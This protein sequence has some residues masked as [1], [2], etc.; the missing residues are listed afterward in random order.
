MKRLLRE[1]AT[2]RNPDGG[3]P[4]R[5]GPSSCG[6]C[7]ASGVYTDND[8]RPNCP[9]L[10]KRTPKQ[11]RNPDDVEAMALA[12][13]ESQHS[14]QRTDGKV[15]GVVYLR[16]EDVEALIRSVRRQRDAAWRKVVREV[17]AEHH[18]IGLDDFFRQCCD[19]IL[20]RA[21]GRTE[22]RK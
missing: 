20:R 1:H 16:C 4:M 12:W 14:T 17:Q 19:T 22:R 15:R 11:S 5:I 6:Y 8:H 18:R 2:P 9:T 3:Q 13:L 21:P 10:R 7:G